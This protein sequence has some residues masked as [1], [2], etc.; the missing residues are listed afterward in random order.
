M[1]EAR[2]GCRNGPEDLG[3]GVA[4]L[5]DAPIDLVEGLLDRDGSFRDM[6]FEGATWE[7]VRK[8]IESLQAQF[9]SIDLPVLNDQDQPKVL[10]AEELVTD[11]RG[12]KYFILNC[13]RGTGIV[14]YLHV[15]VSDSEIGPHVE[16]TFAP[17]NL[18][19]KNDLRKEFLNWADEMRDA[20]Q[21]RRY[22]VRYESVSWTFGDTGENSGVF[23]VSGHL[24]NPVQL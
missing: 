23:Y 20:L 17:Y 8:L 18:R 9:A 13:D 7:G 3:H 4:P 10:N 14:I 6:N 1:A 19:W 22:F 16:F 5:L 2:T 15:F 21:A 12:G 11:A 24:M